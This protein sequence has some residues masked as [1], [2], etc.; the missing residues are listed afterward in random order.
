MSLSE[1]SLGNL[2]KR[3][4]LYKLNAYT[5]IFSSM[6]FIQAIAFFFSFGT[7]ASTGSGSVGYDIDIDYHSTDTVIVFTM[8]WAFINAMMIITKKY[9]EDDF[10]FVTNRLSNNL[11][12]ILFLVVASVV[13]GVTA[14]L[15]TFLLRVISYFILQTQSII[16]YDLT[17]SVLEVLSGIMVTILYLLV[18]CSLG[19]IV[20]SIIQL[21]KSLAV[22]MPVV[23]VGLLIAIGVLGSEALL[24]VIEFYA[25]ETNT[26]L[27][28]CKT[29]ITSILLFTGATIIS[30]RLEVRR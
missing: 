23:A 18:F 1:I 26:L 3:Q 21:H 28:L 7:T 9:R 17:Y 27:F 10:A 4:F 12:N 25:K 5:G 29:V 11:A 15:S 24:H 8:L 2:V 14:I 16:G 22:I 19:Y 13:G 6:I 30:N 20:G